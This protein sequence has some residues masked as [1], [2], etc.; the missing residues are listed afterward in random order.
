MPLPPDPQPGNRPNH[1]PR[2]VRG[3]EAVHGVAQRDEAARPPARGAADLREDAPVQVPGHN[4]R[5]RP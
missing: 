1:S 2:L 3:Q 4:L 5:A